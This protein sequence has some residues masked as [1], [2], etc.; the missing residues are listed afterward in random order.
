MKKSIIVTVLAS[1]IFT[2]PS[3]AFLSKLSESNDLSSM[4]SSTLS[5]TESNSALLTQITSQLPVSQTQ[6]AGGVG[7]LLALAQNQ[8]SDSNSS[9]LETLLPGLN[10]LTSLSESSSAIAK[11]ANMEAVN[12]VFNK[13]GLDSSMVAQFAPLVLQYL[14]SQGASSDLL[15]SLSSLWQ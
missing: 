13:L 9:E 3:Y 4:V 14:T 15:G 7:S 12:N 11:I 2:A 5:Q 1:T 10:Q 6:A 8:L